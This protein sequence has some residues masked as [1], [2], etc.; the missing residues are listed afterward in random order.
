MH[1]SFSH[2][3]HSHCSNKEDAQNSA[4]ILLLLSIKLR[5]NT[6]KQKEGPALPMLCKY[7][8]LKLKLQLL[9]QPKNAACNL[10]IRN[11]SSKS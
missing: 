10:Y 8:S 6:T 7:N 1:F 2:F 11:A 4:N 9:S 3:I 5:F